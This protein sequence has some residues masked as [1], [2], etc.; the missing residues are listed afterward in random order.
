MMVTVFLFTHG[1]LLSINL[2]NNKIDQDEI[3]GISVLNSNNCTIE[4]LNIE[5]HV[6][7]DIFQSV[8]IKY[9]KLFQNGLQKISMRKHHL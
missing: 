8:A 2:G 6:Y 5:N 9:G 4:N 1:K 7:K 3:I